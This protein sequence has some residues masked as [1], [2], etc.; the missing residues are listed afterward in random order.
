MLG[1]FMP[2]RI[3][4]GLRADHAAKVQPAS[5]RCDDR[6]QPDLAFCHAAKHVHDIVPPRG[7]RDAIVDMA[8]QGRKLGSIE[9]HCPQQ[10]QQSPSLRA[11]VAYWTTTYEPAGIFPRD[12][13]HP[14]QAA[15]RRTGGKA[16]AVAVLMR[17]PIHIWL[18]GEKPIIR[19]PSGA[20][21]ALAPD[22]LH[23]RYA[24]AVGNRRPPSPGWRSPRARWPASLAKRFRRNS[25]QRRRG[26]RG[27]RGASCRYDPR[28]P[29][30][31]LQNAC[32]VPAI[33]NRFPAYLR[34]TYRLRVGSNS[35]PCLRSVAMLHVAVRRA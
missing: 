33:G 6:D 23:A 22:D 29:P 31:L 19:L 3:G 21:A 14:G 35:W 15:S 2:E 18:A 34:R 5:R 27:P 32:Q 24:D 8:D 12:V 17:C 20:I 25:R 9:H 13:A 16:G 4:D 11:F 28:N 26:T 10:S 1:I 30:P 7:V